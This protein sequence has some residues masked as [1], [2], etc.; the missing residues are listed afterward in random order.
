MH[1]FAVQSSNILRSFADVSFPGMGRP[2]SHRQRYRPPLPSNGSRTPVELEP[3]SSI[4][5]LTEVRSFPSLSHSSLSSFLPSSSCD[6]IGSLFVVAS[7][8]VSPLFMCV[9]HLLCARALSLSLTQSLS[10]V[11]AASTTV[12]GASPFLWEWDFIILC[13]NDNIF[14]NSLQKWH[15]SLFW[16]QTR[17][18]SSTSP[19]PRSSSKVCAAF[20]QQ[21]AGEQVC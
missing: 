18:T 15:P 7:F 9:R 21:G 1:V 11:G 14:V 20:S 8:C 5:D 12:P 16:T 4:V 6:W 3:L 2:I 13:D 19:S 10:V 17:D